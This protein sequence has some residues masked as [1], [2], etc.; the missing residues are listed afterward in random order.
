MLVAGKAR[1][2]TVTGLLV[3]GFIAIIT[4]SYNPSFTDSSS[5]YLKKWTHLHN[6]EQGWLGPA[7]PVPTQKQPGQSSSEKQETIPFNPAAP[8][9]D[10]E[11][12]S[13]N[14]NPFAA[15]D[16][17]TG[18]E[19]KQEHKAPYGGSD[20]APP[21]TGAVPA[22]LP[23]EV[24]GDPLHPSDV[25]D[26]SKW[27]EIRSQSVP[28]GKYFPVNFY[29]HDNILAINPNII[30]HPHYNDTWIAVAQKFDRDRPYV[31]GWSEELV[32]NAQFVAGGNLSCNLDT[33]GTLTV[34]ATFSPNCHDKL[35]ALNLNIGPH[36]ARVAYGPDYPYLV[37]GSQSHYAC[38]G[39]WAQDFRLLMDWGLYRGNDSG[40]DPFQVPTEIQRPPPWGNMEKN[41]YFF[42]D[43]NKTMYVHHDTAPQRVFA[44]VEPDGSVGPDLSEH[45]RPSDSFCWKKHTGLNPLPDPSVTKASIHQASNSL[46]ITMCNRGECFP[47]ATNTFI[48]EIFQ[49][50]ISNGGP[51]HARY[52]P[53][54]TMFQR[55]APFQMHAISEKPLWIRGRNSLTEMLYVTSISWKAKDM[56][57]EGFLDD[58]MFVNF[59]IEDSRTASI[60]VLAGDL[61]GGNLMLCDV[62]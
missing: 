52:E 34:P 56:K 49:Q 60:D 43:F 61:V 54:V 57:Y 1:L 11:L 32:C 16:K 4:L 8:K 47:N 20:H 37:Y 44:K 3:V 18:Q 51:M 23:T 50:K 2:I 55:E 58:E 45:A 31:S 5:Q 36:D 25:P 13:T 26:I 59:G 21:S 17:F 10:N 41:F 15:V 27:H 12:P 53:F 9:A 40:M 30:P 6:E 22:G 33:R 39:Q 48:I 28:Q 19:T 62:A 24:H 7:T 38:F 46:S 42:W 14:P 35:M 29:D